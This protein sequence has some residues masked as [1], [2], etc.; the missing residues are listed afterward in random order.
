MD[1]SWIARCLNESGELKKRLAAEQT[2]NIAKASQAM[3]TALARGGKVLLFGNGGSAADAQH[4]AAEFVGRF[5][6]EREPLPA[7]ALTTDTSALTAI[8]NDYGFEQVF[9][10]QVRAL[11]RT[12]DVVVAISTSGRSVN[13]LS[14]LEAARERGLITIGLTGGDGG[15]LGRI[16]DIPIIVPSAST[17]R[18]QECHIAVGHV[19][20]EIVEGLVCG[21]G[22]TGHLVAEGAKPTLAIDTPKMVDWETLLA[23]RR[24]WRAEGKTVVWTNGCF[25]LLHVG[26]V[27]N[28]KKARSL[29][30]ILVVGVNNDE[31]VQQLKGPGRPVVPA[32]QR[33]EVLAALECINYVV[34]FHEPTPELALSRLQPEIHCKGADYA[35]PY[36]KPI[37]EEQT[38]K[39]YGGRVEFLPIFPSISTSDLIR[40]ICAQKVG[41]YD[42]KGL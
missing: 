25:D 17:A 33:V 23:L 21:E 35:P 5:A 26:H 1:I 38:V 10:R 41:K 7:I 16:V 9:A 4:I 22:A 30:D 13:V 32:S 18:I 28:L 27:R 31:S 11:G 40:R 37:P 20:C 3:A 34:V 15:L 14:G 12:G 29:G 42:G 36:G 24:R 8:G 39:S 6:Q 2:E 19:L